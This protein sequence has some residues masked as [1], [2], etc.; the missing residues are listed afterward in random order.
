MRIYGQDERRVPRGDSGREYI[1]RG[2]I[3]NERNYATEKE[4]FGGISTILQNF[5][6][7]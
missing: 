4:Y 3:R 1:K 2:V 5:V 7:P 6:Y